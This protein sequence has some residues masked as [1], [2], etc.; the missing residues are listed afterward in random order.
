MISATL[1]VV[2]TTKVMIMVRATSRMPLT[3]SKILTDRE[4]PMI[5]A[6]MVMALCK[7]IP[8][9]MVMVSPSIP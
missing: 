8:M 4:P 5:T 2:K 9:S 1:N 7:K 3:R 6:P